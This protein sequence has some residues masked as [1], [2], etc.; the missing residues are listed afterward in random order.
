MNGKIALRPTLSSWWRYRRTLNR[1]A[2]LAAQFLAMNIKTYALCGAATFFVVWLTDVSYWLW[3]VCSVG[4][5]FALAVTSKVVLYI[6]HKR[7]V[8]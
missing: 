1:I 4:S 8:I 5:I 3:I 6:K 7:G 2:L